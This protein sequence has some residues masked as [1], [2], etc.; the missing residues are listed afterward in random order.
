MWTEGRRGLPH[1]GNL[2]EREA[3]KR[4]LTAATR[5]STTGKGMLSSGGGGKLGAGRVWRAAVSKR[6]KIEVTGRGEDEGE[7]E[8]TG[9]PARVVLRKPGGLVSGSAASK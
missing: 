2:K 3:I 7:G 5:L 8:H 6:N 4:R 1:K 9:H